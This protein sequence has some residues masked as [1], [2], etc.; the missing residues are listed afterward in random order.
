ML[1]R[2]AQLDQLTR[3]IDAARGSRLTAQLIVGEP[4]IGKSTLLAATIERASHTAPTIV[5]RFDEADRGVPYALVSELAQRI[6]ASELID[7]A[8]ADQLDQLSVNIH[9]GETGDYVFEL[10]R[11]VRAL[12]TSSSF[13]LLVIGCE[14]VHNLDTASLGLLTGVIRTLRDVPMSVVMTGRTGHESRIGNLRRLLTRM[15][16]NGSGRSLELSPFDDDTVAM[17]V[18]EV[19]GRSL[20]PDALHE[21]LEAT[22]GNPFLVEQYLALITRTASNGVNGSK[23]ETSGGTNGGTSLPGRI[24][25]STGELILERFFSSSDDTWT[26][27]Q[28]LSTFHGEVSLAN[29]AIES[30]AEAQGIDAIA[31]GSAWDTLVETGVLCRDEGTDTYSFIHPLVSRALYESMGAG[32]RRSAHRLIA[33]QLGHSGIGARRI[34]DVA[35]HYY[36][37][38]GGD[39]DSRAVDA[40]LQAAADAE[41]NAPAVADLWLRRCLELLPHGDP[42]RPDVYF[43]LISILV[44]VWTPREAMEVARNA[45]KEFGGTPEWAIITLPAAIA[46]LHSG[47]P[48]LSAATLEAVSESVEDSQLQFWIT[49]FIPLAQFYNG[50]IERATEAYDSCSGLE[51]DLTAG[52]ELPTALSDANLAAYTLLTGR[53]HEYATH[54]ERCKLAFPH[55]PRHNHREIAAT[56]AFLDLIGP[57][58]VADVRSML[59]AAYD[60]PV[61]DRELGLLGAAS[62]SAWILIHWLRGDLSLAQRVADL[63]TQEMRRAGALLLLSGAEAVDIMV[64]LELGS[65]RHAKEVAAAM[66]WGPPGNHGLVALARSRMMQLDGQDEESCAVLEDFLEATR[67]S[68]LVTFVAAVAEELVRLRMAAGEIDRAREI[69]DDAYA[70][71]A[72]LDWA[73]QSMHVLRARGIAYRRADD[74]A[75]AR[76]IC[77]DLGLAFEEHVCD[78]VLAELGDDPVERLRRALTGFRDLGALNSARSAQAECRRQG[79]AVPRRKRTDV[80]DGDLTAAE[81]QVANLATQGLSNRQIADSLF[82]S[83]K[84]VELYLSRVYAKEGVS[85]RVE[86]TAKVLTDRGTA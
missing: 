77:E 33:E 56:L 82:I 64:S 66:E 67:T 57:G 4:G 68:G 15:E 70:R 36:L 11:W 61:D 16:A 30:L 76:S 59:N 78:L 23:G 39:S 13:D 55:I 79:I 19:T 27:A 25:D 71:I 7:H 42:R 52:T 28:L 37:G 8:L 51:F 62:S 69:A 85:G 29:S 65:V 40:C 20:R 53:S 31:F 75:A 26:V 34:Y 81:L 1:G 47:E 44:A 63:A 12:F 86:L 74:V 6:R 14:D 54:F 80:S 48:E 5:C 72:P 21:L 73:L 60:R 38:R 50:R 45:E 3:G 83:V 58:R 46:S 24:G 41:Q 10:S 49:S 9:G 32:K 18:E 2:H 35:T 22:A 17:L 84:T 43:R